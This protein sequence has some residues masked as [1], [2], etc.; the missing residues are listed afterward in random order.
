MF[1]N[2]FVGHGAHT[3]VEE[4]LRQFGQGSQMQIREQDQPRPEKAIF[5]QAAALSLSRSGRICS[6]PPGSGNNPGAR[7]R[8]FFI[9]DGTADPGLRFDK[10]LMSPLVQRNYHARYAADA[11]FVV[12]DF[13]WYA[14][15]HDRNPC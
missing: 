12:F 13:P 1:A 11:R 15:N 6:R 5:G 4:C 14:D 7:F 2:R 10:N 8:I 3:A 9:S